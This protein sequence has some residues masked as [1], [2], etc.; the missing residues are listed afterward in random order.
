V[1][2]TNKTTLIID[3]NWLLMSRLGLIKDSFNKALSN[4]ELIRAKNDM[5]DFVAQSINKAI[6]FW[7]NLIDNIIMV[8]DSGSWRKELPKPKLYT[9]TY[10]GNRVADDN[11]AWDYVWRA[12][13][14]ICKNFE[15]NNITCVAE[16]SI[17][18]DDWCW[19]WSRYLNRKGVNTII[20]TSDSDLKQLVQEDEQTGAWTAWYNDKSGLV[21]HEKYDRDD[22]DILMDFDAK[23]VFMEGICHRVQ[24][25]K[26]INPD[27]IVMDKVICGD[28][29]DN[30]KSIIR[31]QTKTTKGTLR[32]LS[33]S[34]N[35][36]HK[37]KNEL[38][39]TNFQQ[40]ESKKMEIIR[41]LRNL[42]RFND[43]CANDNE[44]AELFDFNIILVRLAKEQIPHDTAMLMNK[45]RDEYIVTD[46]GYLH[47]NYKVLGHQDAAMNDLFNDIPF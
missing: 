39:I 12:L 5:V 3:G 6:N 11:V 38:G 1:E 37:V 46:M 10:K 17:E 20:W 44:I 16:K 29:G 23:N 13:D 30:I 45:H 25:V 43:F 19:Y 2:P 7:S 9:E 24:D 8:Q 14:E 28:A 21:V 40:F 32:T 18:G 36:W 33:V 34:L 42:P 4:N 35:E 41:N 26:Y 22:M 47:N 15:N 31:Y 27:D